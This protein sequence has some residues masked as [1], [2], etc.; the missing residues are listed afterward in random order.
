[1]DLSL[2]II[3]GEIVISIAVEIAIVLFVMR[4]KKSFEMK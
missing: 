2:L 3:L 1:M 4:E